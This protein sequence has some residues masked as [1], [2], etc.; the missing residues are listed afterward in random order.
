MS[1]PS[2]SYVFFGTGPLAESVLAALVRGGHTPSLVVTKE[3]K[4]QGR[5]MTVTAPHIKTWALLKNIPVLQPTTLDNDFVA[6]LKQY[7]SDVYVVASYGKIIPENVLALPTHGALNVHPSLL[8]RYRGAS[9]I[10]SALLSGD[11]TTGVTIIKLDSEMDHGPI[12]A[13]TAFILNQAVTSSLLEVECGQLG[14]ELLLQ[15]I[16]HYVAGSLQ[17]KEQDHSQ[18]TF[19]KK[20]TKAL[21]E[22][23]L[24]DSLNEVRRK[25]RALTPWPGI[26]F[27]H[28]HGESSIRVKIT[29]I[30]LETSLSDSTPLLFGIKR[31]IPEGKKEMDFESFKRGYMN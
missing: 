9:P 30:D 23:T 26:Y 29:E 25:Y 6:Q 21:G 3:D 12:L 24:T 31:V 27:F 16:P 22:V 1:A 28:T 14:G 18:A 17:P 20:I 19:C 5:H 11:L 2:F 10:E 7:P 13:Q 4:P 8:P 15:T